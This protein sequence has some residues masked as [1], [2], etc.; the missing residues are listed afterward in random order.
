MPTRDNPTDP[1]DFPANVTGRREGMT[2]AR[3]RQCVRRS[4]QGFDIRTAR[5]TV[6]LAV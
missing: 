5:A 6:T 4:G 2:F 1:G 3:M